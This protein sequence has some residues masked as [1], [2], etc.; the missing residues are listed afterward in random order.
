[1]YY[2]NLEFTGS[3]ENT[4]EN[5]TNFHS[6]SDSVKNDDVFFEPTSHNQKMWMYIL[7]QVV[8]QKSGR[9]TPFLALTFLTVS[10]ES[11]LRQHLSEFEMLR[12]RN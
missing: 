7:R 10:P 6:I 4:K 8:T 2:K 12:L 1:M 9:L 11:P 5:K 3:V